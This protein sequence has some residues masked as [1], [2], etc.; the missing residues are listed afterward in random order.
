M[1]DHLRHRVGGRPLRVAIDL[2]PL[3]Y[4]FGQGRSDY[5]PFGQAGVPIVFFG[6][7][8]SGCY[9]T[10]GDE[11]SRVDW[12]KLAEQ[13]AT[14]FRTTVGLSEAAAAPAFEAP[15]DEA[16]AETLG[17]KAVER[18]AELPELERT[19]AVFVWKGRDYPAARVSLRSGDVDSF[20][21]VERESGSLETAYSASTESP[22]LSL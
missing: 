8:S 10:A 6:D 19:S 22:L 2:T 12:K 1:H 18:A 20:T 11:P 9:H 15:L 7:G 17:P 4:V 13:S 5:Y 16:D 21:V 3:S 14:A